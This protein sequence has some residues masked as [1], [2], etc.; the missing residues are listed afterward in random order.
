MPNC[1][2]FSPVWLGYFGTIIAK[3]QR[4]SIQ[5][6]VCSSTLAVACIVKPHAQ[7]HRHTDAMAVL[8][9]CVATTDCAEIFGYLFCLIY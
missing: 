9:T 2:S 4:G 1:R 3:G 5:S 7:R 6:P 8:R